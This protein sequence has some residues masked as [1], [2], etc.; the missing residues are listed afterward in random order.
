MVQ[1]FATEIV[2]M[3]DGTVDLLFRFLR[4]NKGVLSKRGGEVEFAKLTDDQVAKIE[5][6]YAIPLLRYPSSPA[7][8]GR[9][10]GPLRL[11]AA[12][13]VCQ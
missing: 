11:A 6:G 7:M 1:A 5:A 4:L 2:D 8:G 13:K 9:A 12:I 3:P 10:A